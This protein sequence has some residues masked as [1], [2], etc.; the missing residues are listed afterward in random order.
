[1]D[2]EVAR[3]PDRLG[4]G[5][6]LPRRDERRDERTDRDRRDDGR[7]ARRDGYQSSFL[8]STSPASKKNSAVFSSSAIENA[9]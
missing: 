4:R 6:L 5:R 2:V 1:M 7:E 9:W 3:Q 8:M